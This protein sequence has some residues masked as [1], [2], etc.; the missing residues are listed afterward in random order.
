MPGA[1]GDGYAASATVQ[2]RADYDAH[3]AAC[4]V[5]RRDE[6]TG[7]SGAQL[8]WEAEDAERR[9]ALSAA[10]VVTGVVGQ[11]H[12]P[13]IPYTEWGEDEEDSDELD[14]ALELESGPLD[15]LG[16]SAAEIY[17]VLMGIAAV[18]RD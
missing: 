6:A 18:P 2:E 3:Y 12:G 15:R 1:D 5:A 14:P 4:A 17:D 9:A 16:S 7:V 13:A 8:W 11:A 10:A